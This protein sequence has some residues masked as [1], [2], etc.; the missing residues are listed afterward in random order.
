MEITEKAFKN[1]TSLQQHKRCALILKNVYDMLERNE[2]VT[3]LLMQYSQLNSW[4]QVP[5][6][7]PM[8]WN[9]KIVSDLYHA[10]L[11]AGE[12]C[13]KEHNLL[14]PASKGDFN[15]PQPCLPIDIY[16]DNL[17]SAHNV[18]S[19][20][21]STEAFALGSLHFSSQTPFID[22]PKVIK[23]AMGCHHNVHCLKDTP[24]ENLRK[25]IIA[26]ETSTNAEPLHTFR[27]PDTFTLVVGNEEYGCSDHTLNLA[28]HIV[29]IPLRG[30]KNSLNVANAFTCV[31]SEITRQKFQG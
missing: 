21:R 4:L 26:I 27:F 18:G 11:E 2:G 9:A 31:A 10:H 5:F 28:T 25:P 20:I 6:Q 30:K 1:L 14:S 22:N 15:T 7:R 29:A 19:I 24:L 3:S 12:I 16:L 17:R 13:L 23:T 8:Q